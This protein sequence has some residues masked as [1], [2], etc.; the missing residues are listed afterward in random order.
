MADFDLDSYFA[1]RLAGPGS[2]NGDG[3]G[4]DKRSAV[5]NAFDDKVAQLTAD[6]A[7]YA[8]ATP[9]L[10]AE[11][12][13]RQQSWVGRTGLDPH[14]VMGSLVNLGANL[15]EGGVNV[16]K[17]LGA[18]I[19]T[20]LATL[21]DAGL[22]DEVK[23]ARARELG[24]TASAEERALLDAPAHRADP[25]RK[26]A[27]QTSHAR[28]Q[29]LANGTLETNRQRIALMEER[30]RDAATVRDLMDVSSVV[31]RDHQNALVQDLKEGYQSNAAQ[32]GQGVDAVKG[33]QLLS[34]SANVVS[35]IAGLLGNIG[36]A[37]VKNPEASLEYITNNLPQ[38]ALA[39]GGGAGM[40]L[41]NIPYAV[42]EFGKGIAA[43]QKAHGGALPPEAE[44]TKLAGWAAS[45]AVAETVGDKLVLAGGKLAP[46]NAA[47]SFKQALLGNPVTRTAGAALEGGVG[48]F[49]T[50]A[51]Q[52]AVE[53]HLEGKPVTA[54]DAYVGGAIG[55]IAGA[56]SSAGLHGAAELTGVN[57]EQVVQ[58]AQAAAA[59]LR[60]D[61]VQQEAISSGDV[62]PLADPAS[63]HYAP[64]RAIAALY[65]HSQQDGTPEE[66]RKTNFK[67]AVQIAAD[68]EEQAT[69]L[70]DQLQ[71]PDLP[72]DQ[73]QAARDQLKV[74]GTQ[75]TQAEKV[76]DVFSQARTTSSTLSTPAETV[77]THAAAANDADPV[78]ANAAADQ[79]LRLGMAAPES[80][81][82][83]VLAQLANNSGNGLS[84]QQRSLL[85]SFSEARVA[86]NALKKLGDV[87]HEIYTGSSKNIGLAQYRAR[88]G[89]ALDAGNQ[90][91]ADSQLAL[92]A[93]FQQ[94]HQNKAAAF[95]QALKDGSGTQIQSLGNNQWQVVQ[96]GTGGWLKDV[97]ALHQNGGLQ[98]DPILQKSRKLSS[99][100][101]QE[102]AAIGKTLA[103]LQSVVAARFGTSPGAPDVAHPA[104]AETPPSQAAPR[105][106]VVPAAQAA[107]PT[108]TAAAS[109][110][111]GNAAAVAAV[112]PTTVPRTVP[113]VVAAPT[114][115]MSPAA[116]APET[117]PPE[118]AAATP[119]TVVAE[120][121]APVEA[122]LDEQGGVLAATQTTTPAGT[123]FQQKRF[124]DFF[125]QLAS[126]EG[127]STLRPLVVVKDFLSALSDRSI[128]LGQ[129]LPLRSLTSQQTALLY[130]FIR[131]AREWQP[132][133]QANQALGNPDFAYDNPIQYLVQAVD[134]QPR[135]EENVTTAM[136]YAGFAYLAEQGG[137]GALNS[138]EEINAILGRDDDHLV[139]DTE[140]RMLG[141]IGSR[142]NVVTNALGQRVLDALGI[143][144]LAAV[145]QNLLP[146]LQAA[147]GL[148]VLKVLL[149]DGLLART[150]LTGAQMAALTGSDNTKEKASFDFVK[151]AHTDGQLAPRVAAILEAVVGSQG[152]LDKLFSVESGLKEPSTEPVPF[153]QKTTRNTG[154]KIP[155]KLAA[156]VAKKQAQAWQINQGM[157]HLLEQFDDDMALAMSGVDSRA[158]EQIHVANQ[159]AVQAKN[160]AL[161]RDLI[162]LRGFVRSMADLAAPL[163]FEYS[164]WKQQRVG[165]ATNVLN[166]QGSKIARQLVMLPGWDSRLELNDSK[167][168]D[169]FWLR[170]GEGLGVK[171][172]KQANAT[173]LPQIRDMVK[174]PALQQAVKV[175]QAIEAGHS[176]SAEEK[177]AVV[178]AVQAGGE[179]LHSLA[180]LRAIAQFQTAQANG[181]THFNAQLM[182]EVDGVTN[183]P[184]LSQLLFGAATSVKSLFARLNKGGF[185]EQ[186]N[187]DSQYNVWR[188]QPGRADLYE[189][190]IR[191]VVGNLQGLL[192]DGTA[193]ARM[194][195]RYLKPGATVPAQ[196]L[197][198]LRNRAHQLLAAIYSFTGNL[199]DEQT[200]AVEK[201]GRNII[202]TPLTAM[203]FG[204]SVGKAVG[205]MADNFI[206]SIYAQIEGLAKATDPGKARSALLGQLNLLLAQGK[207]PMVAPDADLMQVEFSKEQVAALQQVFKNTLGQAVR[208]TMEQDF[209]EFINH[210]RA[211]NSAAQLTFTLYDAAYR[212]LRDSFL[213]ELVGQGELA[214]GKANNPL[215]GLTAQQEQGLA[216][217][218]ARLTPV[219]Q[220]L[221]GQDSGAL[222]GGLHI[223]KSN[224]KLAQ[225]PVYESQTVFGT[226]FKDSGAKTA[227]A[228]GYEVVPTDPGVAMAVMDVHATDSAISHYAGDGHPILNIHD[229]HGLGLGDFTAGAQRLNQQTWNALLHYSPPSQLFDSL[230]RTVTG[231]AELLQQQELPPQVQAN[232]AE[233]LK[234]FGKNND[235]EGLAPA[236]LLTTM[237]EQTQALA[238]A[239]DDIKLQALSQLQ[240]VDQYAL[241]GGN[242]AVTEADRAEAE[243]LHQALSPAVPAKVTAALEQITAAL[244]GQTDTKPATPVQPETVAEADP[245][246][247]E[248]VDPPVQQP[249][250]SAWGALG[251]PR[252]APDP[253]L[254]QFFEGT[255]NP[256][257]GAVIK[258]LWTQLGAGATPMQE[259]YKVL[260]QALRTT[261][262]QS[263]PVHYITPGMA[264][265]AL[266]GG[267]MPGVSGWY[268]PNTQAIQVLS[269]DFV[270]AGLQP[271][272]LLHEMLH[273][274]L[275]AT[276]NKALDRKAH[277]VADDV[278]Q[279]VDE[280][281]K[282]RQ[283][284]KEY[285]AKQALKFDYELADLHEFITYGMTNQAFREQVLERIS[286]R[287]TTHKNA[288]VTAA[289][290]FFDL[291]TGILFR[292]KGVSPQAKTVNG[293]T[294][295]VRNVSGLLVQ[296]Q[297]DSQQQEQ[298]LARMAGRFGMA[299]PQVADYTTHDIYAALGQRGRVSAGFDG[300]LRRLLGTI[301]DK[302]HGP[303]GVFADQVMKQ[304]SIAPLDVWDR[305][306]QTGQAP[307]ASAALNAGFAITQQEAFVL[308]Q[309]EVTVKA[310]LDSNEAQT[311]LAYKE[312]TRLYDEAYGKLTAEDFH[313]GDWATATPAEQRRAEALYNFVF[314]I[315][316]NA[317][318]RSDYLARFAALGLAHERVNTLLR[319]NT[320]ARPQAAPATLAERL[321]R[322]FEQALEFFQSKITHTF[323][324]QPADAKLLALVD[325]LVTI[326]A[327]KRGT[328]AS[329]SGIA[330]LA[331]AE[332]AV[333]KGV[334]ALKHG[335]DAVAGSAF[336]R[337]HANPFL[338][339]AGGM[340]R[341]V[342]HN[343]LA[344]FAAGMQRLRDQAQ[345][346]QNG[347]LISVLDE[348]KGPTDRNQALLRA[349]KGN[350]AERKQIITH[351]AAAALGGFVNGGRDL[352][353]AASAGLSAT[354]LRTGAHALLDHLSL[355]ELATVLTDRAALDA[356]IAA[357]EGQLSGPGPF[358]NF[359]KAKADAL[360]YYKATGLVRDQYLRLNAHSI[361]R[362]TGSPY[363]TRISE[364]QAQANQP[365]IQA[366]VALYAVSHTDSLHRTQ[367]Q[368]VLRQENQRSDGNGVEFM[369]KL[370]AYLEG[371]S[372]ARLFDGN[373][374]LMLHGY[375]PEIYNPYTE[376]QTAD[377]ATGQALAAKGWQRVGVV[378]L[379]PKDPDPTRKHLYVLR[380]AGLS[381]RVTGQVAFTGMGAKGAKAHDGY[382][383][384][385]TQA[386]LQN[387]QTQAA[388]TAAAVAAD[389]AAFNQNGRRDFSRES[390]SFLAPLFNAQGQVV[391]WR[392]MMSEAHKDTLLE[393]DNRFDKL[394]GVLAGSIYDKETA[395][396]QNA[397]VVSALHDVFNDQF[398]RD[399]D[400]FLEV[401]P[402]S[403][404]PE[405]RELWALLPDATK[406]DVRRI[407]GHDGMQVRKDA[408]RVVFGYRK[409]S[410]AEIL[411]KDAAD[412]GHL[413]QLFAGF[414]EALFG[415][416]AQTKVQKVERMWQEV[417]A[418]AKDNIVVKSWSVLK[419]NVLSNLS[420]LL[421]QGVPVKQLLQHHLVALKGAR[422]YQRDQA[423][424]SKL[425]YQRE[426]GY[427][428][429][430]PAVA[431]D[432]R[433]AQLQDAL[434]RNPVKELVDAGL[435]PSIVEDIASEDDLY[436]YK[437]A[438]TKQVEGVTGGLHPKVK[439]VA[440]VAYM[441]HD[442]ALYQALHRATQLSDF[443][444]RYTLYQHLV[445]RKDK[446]LPKDAAIQQ[447]SDAFIN[448]DIPMQRG[449]QYLD[450]MG[451]FMFSKYFLRIQRVIFRLE[452]NKPGRVLATMALDKYRNLGP[453]VLDSSAFARIGSNPLQGGAL[454]FFGSLD[455]LLTVKAGLGLFK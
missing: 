143:R 210:R 339:A 332:A 256:T 379:D 290:K 145:P 90:A 438:L 60:S 65:G 396:Q 398:A 434:A 67:Q 320:S 376:L 172:D 276:V 144:A 406:K 426:S 298:S 138:P 261:A 154:Q 198:A 7:A 389:R 79:L 304:Q 284:A 196:E 260:L 285:V 268:D 449:M 78:V 297:R 326:E 3:G 17:N 351:A 402:N 45:L 401:G 277:G 371:E 410:L 419:N 20:G 200:G 107:A 358:Q 31:Q 394:L 119:E 440:S 385:R 302:L 189:T 404:D 166:P 201:A 86:E 40:A 36:A 391:N 383:N 120:P 393:R 23:A 223:A 62:T 149:D 436:S 132:L 14:G 390:H 209:K 156:I 224:R 215:H 451:F 405:M 353:D 429:G 356:K 275:V 328:L 53:N 167:Q 378:P 316:L 340:V 309:V 139:S 178:T 66:T 111:A 386:G 27:D 346:G 414:A 26:F 315:D 281:D 48:E 252:I 127:D 97:K 352:T 128:K 203:T 334:E 171:T 8:A 205:S 266:P 305:A 96:A 185:F 392:Y 317:H 85:R 218:L 264:V 37:A 46:K 92:L 34:G 106:E 88:I 246:D 361:A 117:K 306:W 233:A 343:R 176:V 199:V 291:V 450:N 384:P 303:F 148:Q 77:A 387:A 52:T 12:A 330:L 56:G 32:I 208:Q 16:E 251:V 87:S 433:I 367:A 82:P 101:H 39:A 250:T 311:K 21:L 347:F 157:W 243:T 324:G 323:A 51:Y 114:E 241:E 258:L 259:V 28:A 329:G 179:N 95:S 76:L 447:A 180:S 377:A 158:P 108:A 428:T 400:G 272:L 437:S 350:E 160:D 11:E 121:P 187:P 344:D 6:R 279:L 403:P 150:T 169:S 237:V 165:I 177:Q 265:D 142:Q 123:P 422:A 366:L 116:P 370:H 357:L 212:G 430:Q 267:P 15:F 263:M 455:D 55:A 226:P 294:V 453:L 50:E 89:Q 146:K 5:A 191:S 269:P 283:K 155:A 443:V 42:D 217:R 348:L 270:N 229:A 38:L 175:L 441:G 188:G 439:A 299:V 195:G 416:S 134:G 242:Y 133:I 1:N 25:K 73:Q 68:L 427:L 29:E 232:L 105:P 293:I 421:I 30:L 446:P 249:A 278:T 141:P 221:L 271:E 118:L 417:V 98:V 197:P 63:P 395:P 10:L 181:D 388:I 99:N 239:A 61:S 418:E 354:L 207:G 282:L 213:Q 420:L 448:Y 336:V 235:L 115:Q 234:A 163:Y 288:L 432:R 190:T 161:T 321:Q 214:V 211:F 382:L 413:E 219:L 373:P 112:A 296:A 230:S 126:R 136:A 168:M 9:Q 129:F 363:A 194:T 125:R 193:L 307:F 444:A 238:Y 415:G 409:Y 318:Q 300:Q 345:D 425:S 151:V 152:V 333:K 273:A 228:R 74:L 262:D 313:D 13:A 109:V 310:A 319:F 360:A 236:D 254:Q 64:H 424:L 337:H 335:A 408:V 18:G 159:F 380:D 93:N 240:A 454:E 91:R 255:P 153:T 225:D 442:S 94:S 407:W 147:L 341:T 70:Q 44:M 452:Q 227:R 137:R 327:K 292:D 124:G 183:G 435:M 247:N 206:E 431:A 33:G 342:A 381:Q 411:T 100:I 83:T 364:A 57:P 325:Q 80:V 399:P 314:K 369:L 104:P 122:P 244:E 397:Q 322:W 362:L 2:V 312:L 216:Q 22:T 173:S 220:T 365:V 49:A 359:W 19:H 59:K 72:A 372:Q 301:V 287:S 47:A 257:I 338:R 24:G 102:A 248:Q 81:D 130:T 202:K 289:K 84:P 110:P 253:A 164:V 368:Q 184:M 423:E 186:G 375:T 222:A 43:Y 58:R 54:E 69:Q 75:I 412:R 349:G 131:Q 308:E 286:L 174:D 231:L 274:A 170:V 113:D 445:G 4:E 355:A 140:K 35:G 331:P 245:V 295:L 71:Q 204:S 280:L 374:T 103:S 192:D 41:T 182:G 135:L 162:N